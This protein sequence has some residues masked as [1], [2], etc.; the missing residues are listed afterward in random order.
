MLYSAALGMNAYSHE[1]ERNSKRSN[2]L[3]P[4]RYVRARDVEDK[5]TL[6]KDDR[7]SMRSHVL[8]YVKFQQVS[9]L[10]FGLGQPGFT[11]R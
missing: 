9:C 7:S 2:C 5:C 8:S 3:A 10:E 1:E 11:L 6:P 4:S